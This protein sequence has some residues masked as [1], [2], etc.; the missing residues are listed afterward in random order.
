VTV[1]RTWLALAE[2]LRADQCARWGQGERVLVEEYL[3]AHPGFTDH[4][5]AVLELVYNEILQREER[6]EVPRLAEYKERFPTLAADLAPLFELHHGLDS[7]CLCGPPED[8]QTSPQA[9]PPGLPGYEVLRE[10]G[11]GGMGV[12]YLA[13]QSRLDRLVALKMILSGAHAGLP[14]LARLRREAVTLARLNHPNFVK[15]HD[16]GEHEGRPFLALEFVNGASLAERLAGTPQP[17]RAAAQL[18]ETLARAMHRAHQAGIIHRDL[19]PANILLQPVESGESRAVESGESRAKSRKEP[20]MQGPLALDSP[21]SALRPKITDFG[22]A[23]LLEGGPDVTDSGQALGTPCY[24]PPE[25]AQG[26]REAIGP[27]ADVYSLGAILYEML[28]GRPPF[29]AE[30]ALATLQQVISCDPVAPGQLRPGLARDL[31]TICLH[32]LRK[33]PGRRYA[34]ALELAEDL[35]RFLAGEPIR[36]RPVGAW[37]K[38]VKWV[39]R[40]PARAALLA[41]SAIVVLTL[42]GLSWWTTITV[43]W[44]NR[45]LEGALSLADRRRQDAEANLED[46]LGLLDSQLAVEKDLTEVPGTEHLWR[47]LSA[48]VLARCDAILQRNPT[49]LVRARA[50]QVR[51]RVGE[52]LYLLGDTVPAE[53]A[54]RG[55]LELQQRLVAEGPDPTAHRRDLAATWNALGNLLRAQRR[56]AEAASAYRAAI[57]HQEKLRDRFLRA[58]DEQHK[59]AVFYQNLGHLVRDRDGLVPAAKLYTTAQALEADLVR[60]HPDVAAYRSGLALALHNHGQMLRETD[61]AQAV[62]MCRSAAELL[63]QVRAQP[64]DQ[65]VPGYAHQLAEVYHN[66]PR[67][68][69]KPADHAEAERCYFRALAL[70]AELVK[71]F[72]L[73]PRYRRELARHFQARG[74]FRARHLKQPQQA[75]A[76]LQDALDLFEKV[77]AF[78]APLVHH[79]DLGSVQSDLGQLLIVSAEDMQAEEVDEGMKL[80]GEGA[81][82]LRKVLELEPGREAVRRRLLRDSYLLTRTWLQRHSREVAAVLLDRVFGLVQR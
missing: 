33:D 17:E 61:R 81:R 10:L 26:Q 68:L 71:R 6:G 82:H 62:R 36:A 60:R 2:A 15:I 64:K 79:L 20:E 78:K 49:P 28:T 21:L 16:I 27:A 72:P 19:K 52:I 12:V 35:R 13:R 40:R 4:P 37:E 39:K 30:T 25:Q 58:P 22:L 67:L 80:L 55:A 76:D 43:Q 48:S 77:P 66:L 75:C 3:A 8:S 54:Y 63:E 9:S 1:E 70:H 24:M 47:R 51:L 45:E 38:A 11:R 46:A 65:D 57:R 32:C 18:V 29:R 44:Y 59:L 23:K 31:E 53:K 34:S 7:T 50:G 14:A 73:V 5:E 41:A 74:L 69:L 56:V 42:L